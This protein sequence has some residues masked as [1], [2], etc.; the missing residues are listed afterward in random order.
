MF[1]FSNVYGLRTRCLS[2]DESSRKGA[3][4]PWW[5]SKAHVKPAAARCVGQSRMWW[6]SSGS[7]W[8]QL[9]PSVDSHRKQGDH[10]T[11]STTTS[12][13]FARRWNDCAWCSRFF[14]P[15]L[16]KPEVGFNLGA[17]GVWGWII[18]RGWGCPLSRWIMNSVPGLRPLGVSCTIIALLPP[19]VKIKTFF[20][21]YQMSQGRP[22]TVQLQWKDVYCFFMWQKL[23]WTSG[24]F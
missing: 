15:H 11:W 21:R 8:V 14:E 6:P 7:W 9:R 3:W 20:R 12:Y 23:L 2:R 22:E 1:S 4:D 5:G 10:D 13:Y 24:Y 17:V 19:V 16:D 18:L